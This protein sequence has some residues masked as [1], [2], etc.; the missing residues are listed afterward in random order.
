MTEVFGAVV[1]DEGTAVP[2]AVVTLADMAGRKLAATYADLDGAYHLNAP[3][4]GTYLVVASAPDHESIASVVS[5]TASPVRHDVTIAGVGGLTGTVR[6]TGT[7]RAVADAV[8]TVVDAQGDVTGTVHTG[9]EG[10]FSFLG[11]PGGDYTLVVAASPYAPLAEPVS[12]RRGAQTR[13]D[14]A[15]RSG[16]RLRGDVRTDGEAPISGAR[17]AV[18]DVTGTT[19]A[20]SVTETDG[21]FLFEDLPPGKYTVVTAGYGPAAVPILVEGDRVAEVDVTLTSQ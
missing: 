19:V 15:V 16:G 21:V 6:Q 10:E 4:G 20:T 9:R 2:G 8:V 12:V 17:I 18:A 11:L 5:V 7:C 14:V 1:G 3:G 13:H